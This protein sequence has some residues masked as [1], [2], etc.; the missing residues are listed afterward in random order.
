MPRRG[1][2]EV[3]RLYQEAEG[4]FSHWQVTKDLVDELLDLY[5]QGVYPRVGAHEIAEVRGDNS[6]AERHRN[7]ILRGVDVDAIRSR[8]FQ[9]VFDGCNG[10]ASVPGPG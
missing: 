2:Q 10:A 5:H 8:K 4:V 7:A 1:S 9:V 6:A 3:E